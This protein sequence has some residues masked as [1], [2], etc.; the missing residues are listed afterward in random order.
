MT[1]SFFLKG[2]P[3]VY[4]LQDLVLP[5]FSGDTTATKEM[6]TQIF[7]SPELWQ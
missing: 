1:I 2:F 5:D 7:G 3:D 6:A 4:C